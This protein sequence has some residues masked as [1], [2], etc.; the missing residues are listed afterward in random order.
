MTDDGTR[1]AIEYNVVRWGET[2]LSPQPGVAVYERG[3]SGLLAAAR[4]YDDVDA[5]LG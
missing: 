5:P 3:R 2:E 1:C 4:V